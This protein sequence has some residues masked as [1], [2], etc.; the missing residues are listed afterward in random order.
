MKHNEQTPQPRHHIQC[1]K[2]DCILPCSKAWLTLLVAGALLAD[3]AGFGLPSEATA[4]SKRAL[5]ECMSPCICM[6][7]CHHK[8]CKWM[9]VFSILMLSKHACLCY[10]LLDI[11]K[12]CERALQED[13]SGQL[14]GYKVA[15][16]L[17][18]GSS[19]QRHLRAGAGLTLHRI[20][21]WG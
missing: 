4:A 9:T 10:T 12:P 3:A 7:H 2:D 20:C 19:S 15:E 1:D 8:R 11:L 5:I 14:C 18:D 17:K 6:G 21:S 13:S 16:S